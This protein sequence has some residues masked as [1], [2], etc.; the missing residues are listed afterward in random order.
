MAH[1]DVYARRCVR[2][3]GMSHPEAGLAAFVVEQDTIPKPDGLGALTL[4]ARLEQHSIDFGSHSRKA[5]DCLIAFEIRTCNYL[6]AITSWIYYAKDS[7][8]GT[9]WAAR[10]RLQ[11]VNDPHKLTRK[12]NDLGCLLC[13]RQDVTMTDWVP[14]KSK[15]ASKE[16]SHRFLFGGL[17]LFICQVAGA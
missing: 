2:Q 11:S 14:I 4:T 5:E 9:G 6:V 7:T 17:K 16:V 15:S 1:A 12:A 10:L 3:I 8:T 13:A